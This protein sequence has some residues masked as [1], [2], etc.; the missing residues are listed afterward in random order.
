MRFL[1]VVRAEFILFHISSQHI[2]RVDEKRAQALNSE[3]VAAEKVTGV[4]AVWNCS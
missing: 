4:P 2:A 1:S 3:F